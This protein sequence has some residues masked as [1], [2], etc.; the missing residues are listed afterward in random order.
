MTHTSS[1]PHELRTL[2][3]TSTA[4]FLA[5]LPQLMGFV[6]TQCLFVVFFSGTRAGPTMRIDLPAHDEPRELARYIDAVCEVVSDARHRLGLDDDPAIVISCTETFADARDIPW[7]RLAVRLQRR[8]RREQVQL[9]ELCCLAGDGWASY[10]DPAAPLSGR[11]LSDIAASPVAPSSP[12]PTL[13]SIGQFGPPDPDEHAEVLAQ[14]DRLGALPPTHTP[15]KEAVIATLLVGPH[16]LSARDVAALI[17]AANRER[18]WL[19]LFDQLTATAAGAYGRTPLTERDARNAGERLRS[20]AYSL[21]RAVE[22]APDPQRPAVI[23]L[24]AV[25]WW[26][27]GIQSVAARQIDVALA[28]DPEHETSHVVNR[29]IARGASPLIAGAA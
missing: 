5:A 26:L 7:R 15:G 27:R 14:L 25:A 2:R 10:L 6:A 23:S 4:D 3:C 16:E 22:H 19:A 9:R 21:V 12:V 17:A 11:P 20:A 28:L 13:E 18:G 1:A 8:L 29:L 24:C